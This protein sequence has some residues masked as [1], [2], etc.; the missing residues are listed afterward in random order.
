MSALAAASSN[1]SSSWV[2]TLIFAIPVLL[3]AFMFWSYYKR[4][5]NFH[6]GQASL[7]VGEEVTTT[8]GLYGTLV[9]LDDTLA[10]LEVA[11]G[12][13]LKFDRRAIVPKS[14]LA[15]TRRAGAD[16]DADRPASQK[17]APHND[18]KA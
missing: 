4:N 1:G 9:E 16:A 14:T 8:S 6:K 13:R 10:V 7:T 15:A 11:D 17:S 2:G 5:R 18:T 12:V 3:L